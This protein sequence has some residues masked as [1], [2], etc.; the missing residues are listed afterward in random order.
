MKTF[1]TTPVELVPAPGS[2]YFIS[3][4]TAFAVYLYG[5]NN[6]F[7]GGSAVNLCWGNKTV[8]AG[9][10]FANSTMIGTANRYNL[11]TVGQTASSASSP[12]NLALNIVASGAD[13][14]GN[15]AND[16]T[17]TVKVFY[18]IFPIG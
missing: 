16:N 12:E 3:P 6:A 17:M 9:Q 2:G 11:P 8:T 7:T 5:G 14:A 10:L 15:A 1:G 4:I 18:Q 13:F